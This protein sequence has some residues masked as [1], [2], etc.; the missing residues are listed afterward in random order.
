M[1]ETRDR[2]EGACG[3]KVEGVVIKYATAQGGMEKKE[4]RERQGVDE[5]SM[6][7]INKA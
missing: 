4:R 6:K 7:A 2:A 3:N 5:E 1:L